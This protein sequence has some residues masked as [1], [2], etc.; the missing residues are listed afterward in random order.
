MDILLL[1]LRRSVNR[2]IYWGNVVR[3]I[4][5]AQGFSFVIM[6]AAGGRQS[7]EVQE[8]RGNVVGGGA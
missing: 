4:W 6:A 3:H 2:I 7:L 5:I 1:L 8:V